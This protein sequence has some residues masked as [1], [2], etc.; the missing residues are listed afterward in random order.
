MARVSYQKIVS[1]FFI[2]WLACGAVCLASGQTRPSRT[3]ALATQQ[4]TAQASAA[5]SAGDLTTAAAI[6]KRVL[7]NTPNNADAQTLAGIIADKKDDLTGAERH[8]A[9]AARLSPSNADAHNNY[10]AILVRL[11]RKKEASR[12]FEIALRLNSKQLSALVNLARIRFEEGDLTASRSL[13]EKARA[14]QAD[15]EIAKALLLIALRQRKTEQAK[16]EYQEYSSFAS[17]PSVIN[18]RYELSKL[19]IEN[20]LLA[21]AITELGAIVS[22]DPANAE[23]AVLL[24]HA[25]LQQKNIPAAGKLL[26]SAVARGID[27]ARIYAALADVYKAGNYFAN[28]IEAMK[29]AV[30]K[31]PDNIDFKF[32]YGLLLVDSKAPAAAVIRLSEYVKE[33][34]Q[35][36]KLWLALGIAYVGDGKSAE[37]RESFDKALAIDPKMLPALAYSANT[38]AE[39]GQY[40]AAAKL[41]ERAITLADGKEPAFLYLLADSL[42]NISTADQKRIELLLKRS[43]ELNQNFGPA[44]SS[45]GT[46]Y[47]RQGRW[48]DAETA[49]ERAAALQPDDSKAVYQLS[50]VYA[51]LKKGEES[52]TALEKFRQLDAEQRER[53]DLD[54]REMVRSLANVRF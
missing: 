28:A 22:S 37:A 6:V 9:I 15:A 33:F 43:I 46:L 1:I 49:L 29:L 10:G 18:G 11:N 54:R 38:Y 2:A 31:A 14:I 50:R 39:A 5:V 26:E 48:I 42:L 40:E 47:I 25:Y 32:S 8:F 45:L 44:F 4:L 13:F 30:Q 24:S 12:E 23:A 41:Y 36:A 7:S 34:P 51:R 53:R 21:E 19:L 17:D 52:Q 16:Q 35:A 20:G 27:D 3:G